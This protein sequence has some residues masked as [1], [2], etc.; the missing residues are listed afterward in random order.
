MSFSLRT[1]AIVGV[2]LL[3][4][5][6]L[7]TIGIIMR[8][9]FTSLESTHQVQTHFDGLKSQVVPLGTLIKN[10]QID[11]IQVQQFLT[12]ISATRGRDGLDDGFAEAEKFAVR[13]AADSAEA[14]A[15][16]AELG[17]SDLVAGLDAVAKSFAAFYEAGRKMAEAYVAEGPSAGN[18]M[19]AD[20]DGR[21][22][23]LDQ[24]LE[25]LLRI[26]DALIDERIGGIASELKGVEAS[27]SDTASTNMAAA[28][29]ATLALFLGAFAFLRFV[30]HPIASLTGVME[31]LTSGRRGVVVPHVVSRTEIGRMARA[32]DVFREAI[33]QREALQAERAAEDARREAERRRE[34]RALADTFA[35]TVSTVVETV[36]RVAEAIGGTAR[37][38]DDIAHTTAGRAGS[39][40]QAASVAS[41]NVATV[42]AATEELT[43]A[44][45]EVGRQM[46]H[47]GAV[48][49][50]AVRQAERTNAIVQDLSEATQRIGEIVDLINA[51]AAQTNLLALNAT[52][53][54][55]RAGDAGR[56]FAVVAQEVKLLAAQTSKAT[57]EIA[58]QIATVQNVT[59]EA[60]SAI[61]DITTTVDEITRISQSIIVA[62]DE[63]ASATRE[64]SRSIDE[65]ARGTRDVRS[66][67]S[68]VDQS[69]R[70]TTE[71]AGTMVRGSDDLTEVADRLRLEVEGFVARMRA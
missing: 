47:A 64:I 16:A 37:R 58:Q 67:I 24:Q 26:R 40:S 20:F 5:L 10:I 1:Q 48:S 28:A 15:I 65:A 69:T 8:A 50:T 6:N 54:A 13:F 19:M 46:H 7:A 55:A 63:Q 51:I 32:T 9:K 14:R 33:E 45:D 66:N 35:A 34:R 29:L 23:A 12:D 31:A 70:E 18:Q 11:T 43:G 39:V 36:G 2:T 38:V 25:T 53:E 21:C 57:E 17:R 49:A 62:V 41:D 71:A 52:I 56:G 68:S 27:I 4:A 42:A 60:V 44:I 59:D 3:I 22:D 30:V 61:R